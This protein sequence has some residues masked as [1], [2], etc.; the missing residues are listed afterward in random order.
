MR[1]FHSCLL[2][3]SFWLFAVAVHANE[4]IQTT[5]DLI[6]AVKA[7]KEGDTIELASGTFEIDATLELNS[8]LTLKG[9]GI[10]KTTLTCGKTWKPS[11]KTLPD[12]EM[13]L[14]GLDTDAYLIR[15]KRDTSGVTISDM[16]LQAPR[17]HGAIFS[18]FHTD[19][20]LHQL[21]VK[22]T[23]WCGIR[24][25][26]MKGGKIHDCEFVDAGGRWSD[27]HPGVNG[28]ITGGGI[29]AVWMSECQI[30]NNRFMRTRM[31]KEHEFYGIKVRQSKRCR[32]HHN[33]INVN[34]SMEFPF[35][36][37]EDNELDHNVCYGTVSIPKYAGG[38]LPKSGKTFHI[39]HNYFKD[40][41]S[42]EF[43]RNGVEIDHNLFDFDPE[44]DHGNLISGFGNADAQGPAVFHNNLVSNPGRGV[45]WIKEV[46][47]NL[48]VRNN[49]ILTRTTITPRKEG[50]F[51]FNSK[52]DFKTITIKDNLIECVGEPRPLLRCKES[53][54]AVVENNKLVNVSDTNKLTNPKTGR[55]VGLELPLKFECG[56][57]GEYSVDGWKVLRTTR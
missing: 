16:T 32:V 17:L 50:L 43:V 30:F 14:E 42:I 56:V 2:V 34:F 11:T 26:G 57:K 10:D 40:S 35:E 36:N 39:H 19:L 7:A 9:A 54:D 38:P 53:Y 3:F 55:V 24:T 37:D 45:I 13:K 28:G 5:E 47:N 6:A 22:E 15:V 33:T 18:W 29:F 48:E 51:G 27:G 49:H 21:R 12:P 8:G 20:H 31:S 23:M 41:Y 1:R 52:C 46:F 25:F 44:A 4:P